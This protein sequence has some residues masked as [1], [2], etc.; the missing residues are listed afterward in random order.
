[1]QNG[2]ASIAKVKAAKRDE[3]IFTGAVL[4][5]YTLV[6]QAQA[7]PGAK[8]WNRVRLPGGKYVRPAVNAWCKLIDVVTGE[9]AR[10]GA[11]A[12]AL[13]LSCQTRAGIV[14]QL[15]PDIQTPGH[16][17]AQT[18]E[19]PQE[20]PVHSQERPATV[21]GGV[22]E[23][24]RQ[25]YGDEKGKRLWFAW[26]APQ[27]AAWWNETH[28]LDA[29]LPDAKRGYA[30]ATWRGKPTRPLPSAMEDGPTLGRVPAGRALRGLRL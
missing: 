20:V 30:L 25:T 18:P 7:P 14:P 17:D 3:P 19:C 15:V 12:A 10:N 11:D 1:M 13:L 8:K 2:T 4:Q 24:W 26:T 27:L 16:L 21:P 23:R 9:T 5:N 29:L 22:D 6:P 28:E